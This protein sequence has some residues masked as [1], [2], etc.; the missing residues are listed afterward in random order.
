MRINSLLVFS[1]VTILFLTPKEGFADGCTKPSTSYDKTYCTA[2][3]FM[4]SDKELN[5]V[6]G[7][8]RKTLKSEIQK[9][10]KTIQLQWIDYRNSSC[11]ENGMIAVDCNFKL[12]KARTEYLRDRLRE[13]K[14]GHCQPQ[15]IQVKSW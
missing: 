5:E 14:T 1:F 10:L 3:L 6:Y 7:Q 13:C 4:E 11:E 8:L 12:N 15:L 9:E 2:K